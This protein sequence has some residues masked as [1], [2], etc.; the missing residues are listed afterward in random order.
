MLARA[1]GSAAVVSARASTP[2][3]RVTAATYLPRQSRARPVAAAAH[4]ATRVVHDHVVVGMEKVVGMERGKRICGLEAAVGVGRREARFLN[5]ETT[6]PVSNFR[7]PKGADVYC[8]LGTLHWAKGIVVKHN[9][10]EP[11]GRFHPYQVSLAG[12]RLIFVPADDDFSIVRFLENEPLL[13]QDLELL[14]SIGKCA[15]AKDRDGVTSQ[16]AEA[17][18]I[19][20]VR[21]PF[22]SIPFLSLSW[23]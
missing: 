3:R 2:L 20:K 7:F 16:H 23:D 12:G 8:Y 9:Y 19:A 10:E 4:G 6:T 21:P 14:Q 13:P 11:N 22:S 5:V 1:A 15:D 18:R 17:T